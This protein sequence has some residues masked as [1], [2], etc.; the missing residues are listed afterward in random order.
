EMQVTPGPAHRAA[1]AAVHQRR[2]PSQRTYIP[3]LLLPELRLSVDS[4]SFTARSH[5]R[6][7]GSESVPG[8]LRLVVCRHL[9]RQI[10]SGRGHLIQ[11]LLVSGT[12]GH[13]IR[14]GDIPAARHDV[15]RSLASTFRGA[16]YASA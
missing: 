13:T 14:V 8:P 4:G 15:L 10:A 3:R 1:P 5:H 6:L 7:A 2:H 12:L 11:E 16:Q 9:L